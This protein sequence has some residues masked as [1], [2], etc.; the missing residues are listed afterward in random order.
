M[1]GCLAREEEMSLVCIFGRLAIEATE[2][3]LDDHVSLI[4]ALRRQFVYP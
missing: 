2:R 4:V 1:D 3:I